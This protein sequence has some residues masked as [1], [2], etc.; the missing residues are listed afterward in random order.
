M[1]NHYRA[2]GEWRARMDE[3][4]QT[5]VRPLFDLA[6]PRANV[7]GDDVFPGYVGE[8]LK[9][10]EGGQLVAT[11]ATW[12]FVPFSYAGTLKAYRNSKARG[13]NN[14][15]S[16][17][18]DTGWPWKFVAR[19]GR[20][21]IPG[22]AFFEWDDGRDGK[23][24]EYRFSYP[25]G[26][27]FFFAGLAGWAEPADTGR[28]LTYTMLTKAAGPDTLSIGHKRQPVILQ[29]DELASFLDPAT[30][31]ASFSTP[32]PGATFAIAPAKEPAP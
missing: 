1:C 28:I 19:T 30:P 32:S 14:A 3:F 13:C 11:A 6:A 27:P 16:E 17:K 12:M 31:I 20:V 26:R 9:P 23:K 18:A 5:K 24:R 7:Q 22:E 4:S 25:D 2:S 29:P 15:Q 8:I 10:E 21:L